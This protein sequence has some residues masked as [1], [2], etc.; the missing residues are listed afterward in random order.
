V[1]VKL[2]ML[3]QIADGDVFGAGDASAAFGLMFTHDE[4]KQRGFT[5]TVGTDEPD[6]LAVLDFQRDGVQNLLGAQHESD[7]IE[8]EENHEQWPL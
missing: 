2:G 3:G 7:V 4:A 8:A 6:A 5:R 1:W